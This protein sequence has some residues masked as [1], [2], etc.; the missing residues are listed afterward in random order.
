ML[1]SLMA[2]QQRY[3]MKVT[4]VLHVGAHLAEEAETYEELGMHN[5]W[6]VEANPKVY[7]HIRK[8][9][10]PYPNQKLIKGLVYSEPGVE[11][12]FNV[13]N[14][15]GMSSS[16]LEFGTHPSFSP[17]TVFVDR[18]TLTTTTIDD[19]VRDNVVTAN[20]LNMDLQGAELHALQGAT[21]YLKTVD[22]V[23]T[24]VNCEEVYI[25]A[26][27]VEQLDEFLEAYR[28]ERMD[29]YWVPDQGWGDALYIKKAMKIG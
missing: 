19:L 20:F 8:N 6:W 23:M 17:D 14:Y 9:T 26:A 22:Y 2:L 1:M 5:V 27:Q 21:E 3:D 24:E 25:G 15:D 18:I 16:I 7:P 11:L 10:R 29:T 12:G 4:G 28:F 13:T